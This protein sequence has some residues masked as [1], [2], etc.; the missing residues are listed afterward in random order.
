MGGKISRQQAKLIIYGPNYRRTIKSAENRERERET[1]RA[2]LVDVT[3]HL[4]VTV[5]GTKMNVSSQHHEDVLLLLT[6]SF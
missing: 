6:Q 3:L 2:A 1:V 4:E 5:F